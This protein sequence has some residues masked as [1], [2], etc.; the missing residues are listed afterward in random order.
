MKLRKRTKKTLSC[1]GEI[2]NSIKK[3]PKKWIE[4]TWVNLPKI[5]LW[6][7]DRDKLIERKKENYE[8]QLKNI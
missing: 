6:L 5:W 4:S 1:L 8:V 2:K 7:W 3:W